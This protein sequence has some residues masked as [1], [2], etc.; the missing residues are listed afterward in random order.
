MR[1]ELRLNYLGINQVLITGRDS[2]IIQFHLILRDLIGD[3]AG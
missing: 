2:K 1:I 3:R